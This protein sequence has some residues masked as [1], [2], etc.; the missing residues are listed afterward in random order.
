M[1]NRFAELLKSRPVLLAD[2]ATG[3]NMFAYGLTS[4]DAPE[5]WN[6]DHPD[7]VSML[8]RSFVDAGSDLF[9]T[10]SFGGN[11]HRLKLHQAEDRVAE[12]NQAA[13]RIARE[14]ADAAS[15]PVIVAGSMGPTGELFEP[16][17]ALTK[18]EGI[19][20]FE[21]QA[22]ALAEGG[23]DILWVETMS[24]REEVEAALHGGAATGL[25]MVCTLSVDTN[26]STMM[27]STPKAF[28]ALC[29]ELGPAPT[30]YGTNCGVGPAEVVAGILA[31]RGAAQSDDLLVAKANCGIPAFVD[32]AI[33]Y[34]GTA[35]LMADYA[36]LALD[37]G[38]RIIGGCCG[39]TPEI[40]RA[41]RDALD[42][43]E[44]SDPPTLET[45]EQRLGTLSA[46]AKRGDA[47]ERAAQ[48][49]ARRSSRRRR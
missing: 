32:G 13:A 3:T 31:L 26:G 21:E 46:G 39:T 30:A 8:H 33:R 14:V 37:A 45:V 5:F 49:A 44:R 25:P 11:R 18:E 15:R 35:E 23:V 17:G 10:N 7:R 12:L 36:C 48:L 24:S 34:G 1:S 2:G 42:A 43:H 29:R 28:V 47:G 38:A 19:A 27:G 41:M 16:L 6:V 20:A 4:G 9:L 22:R 40:V